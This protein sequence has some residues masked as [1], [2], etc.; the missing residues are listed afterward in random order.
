MNFKLPQKINA[1]VYD[2]KFSEV[3]SGSIYTIGAKVVATCLGLGVSA[4]TARF[5]GAEMMGVLS[6]IVSFLMFATM[7]SVAGTSVSILRFIPEHVTR[8]SVKS[9]FLV[10]RKNL[11]FVI[12]VSLLFG[13]FFFFSSEVIAERVF[14]KPQLAGLF[15]LSS[16]FLIFNALSELTTQAVRGLKLIRT[17]AFMQVLRPFFML[18]FLFILTCWHAGRNVPVYALLIAIGMSAIIGIVLVAVSFRKKLQA[19]DPVQPVPL[20]KI[21]KISLPMFMTASMHYVVG[22]TGIVMLG[23]FCPV[24]EVGYYAVAVKLATLSTFTLQAINSM[25]APKFSELFHSGKMDELFYVAQKSAKLIFWTTLPVLLVL[26]GFGKPLLGFF[27]G[28]EFVVAYWPL[29][30]LLGGQFVNSVCGSTGY[31]MD[32]TGHQKVFRNIIAAAAVINIILNVLLIPRLGILGAAVSAMISVGFW[33]LYTVVYVKIKYNR[34][35]GY[36][37]FCRHEET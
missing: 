19:G 24:N 26:I 32:M 30:F 21:I 17:F 33:N 22:Q 25:A 15:A 29:L 6:L 13:I 28:K 4:F 14:S 11:Y 37:P 36:L 20:F 10:Y 8:Y 23:V 34:M 3:L 27:F 9:A 35:I 2:P 31:F 5:Y 16:L 7:L 18:L 1:F 12:V